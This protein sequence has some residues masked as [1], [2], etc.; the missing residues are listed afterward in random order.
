[1]GLPVTSEPLPRLKERLGDSQLLRHSAVVMLARVASVASAFAV[2]VLAAHALGATESGFFLLGLS[3]AA[4]ASAVGRFG[5]DGTVLRLTASVPKDD[6]VEVARILSMIVMVGFVASLLLAIAL[7]AVAP[8][9]ASKVFAK[10]SMGSVIQWL[11]PGIAATGF[12]FVLASVLQGR[13]KVIAAVLSQGGA[14]NVLLC[15]CFLFFSIRTAQAAALAYSASAIAALC[16]SLSWARRWLSWRHG[17]IAFRPLL[18]SCLPLWGALLLQQTATWAGQLVA[19]ADVGP[20]DMAIFAAAQR[21]AMVISFVLVAMNFVVAPRF[22]ELF[23]ANDFIGVK[24][25]SLRAS[26]IMLAASLPIAL[27]ML[28]WPNRLMGIFGTEFQAG[29]TVLLVL[30]L[31]Q[32]VNSVTGPVGYILI[33]GRRESDY[34]FSTGLGAMVAVCGALLLLPSLG[35]LGAAIGTACG[36]ASQ[37]VAMAWMVKVR[38]FN[39]VAHA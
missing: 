21:M 31:G 6:E 1:M 26:A 34:L 2:S 37:N 5:L 3:G 25:L 35:V 39:K 4:F 13:R 24:K 20:K 23:N 7:Y 28:V 11:S 29:G 12:A 16:L 14:T 30:V 22:A 32:I 17:C 8:L 36:M 19:A 27:P 10:P 15:L 18:K 38:I 33:T 9:L